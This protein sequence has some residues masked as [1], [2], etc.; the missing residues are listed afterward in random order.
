MLLDYRAYAK[1]NGTHYD[2]YSPHAISW[3]ELQKCGKAQGID[4]RPESQGGD[5]KVGDILMIRSGFVESYYERSPEERTKLALRGHAP[6]G[7]NDDGQQYA[8]LAQEE[9]ILDW[10]HDSYFAGVVGDAP[11]F[12]RWPTPETYHLHEYILALW[13]MPLG[14][15]WNLERLA[16][17][18]REM[19]RWFFFMTSAPANVP[20]MSTPPPSAP[21]EASIL[22]E[23]LDRIGCADMFLRFCS[24]RKL[25]CECNCHLLSERSCITC[26]L[27]RID[28]TMRHAFPVLDTGNFPAFFSILCN[29]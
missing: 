10:L 5:I 11:A 4:I 20:G 9:A 3:D 21:K 7:E 29:T 26:R 25:A 16:A 15:M 2:S 12:E 23:R 14:E 17:K 27:V 19:N 28:V 1:A 13:G 22:V 8:G 24:W 18:C 6:G